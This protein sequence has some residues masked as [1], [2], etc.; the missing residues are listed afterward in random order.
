LLSQ[1]I[2]FSSPVGKVPT[3]MS[4]IRDLAKA[5]FLAEEQAKKDA[6]SADA[7]KEQEK[8]AVLDAIMLDEKIKARVAEEQVRMLAERALVEAE[9]KRVLKE[10]EE[11]ILAEMER[12]RNRTKEEVLQETILDL[13]SQVQFLKGQVESSRR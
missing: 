10:K 11:A 9:A 6:A 3:K 12:L 7:K 2:E 8:Q 1:K 5:R 4:D 13:S